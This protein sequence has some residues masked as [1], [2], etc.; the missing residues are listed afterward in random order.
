MERC[1]QNNMATEAKIIAWRV[2]VIKRFIDQ[3]RPLA[4]TRRV[5]RRLDVA[6]RGVL[7]GGIHGRLFGPARFGAP[8]VPCRE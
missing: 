7:P 3:D 4:E 2:R 8:W 1:R 6:R 5:T